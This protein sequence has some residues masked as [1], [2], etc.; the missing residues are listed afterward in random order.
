MSEAEPGN[1]C[2][3]DRRRLTPR[4]GESLPRY[5]PLERLV[6]STNNDK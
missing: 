5:A 2:F 3:V 4:T 6:P 1:R